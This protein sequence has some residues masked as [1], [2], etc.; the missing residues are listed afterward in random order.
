MSL[1]HTLRIAVQDAGESVRTRRFAVTLL[2]YLAIS[3]LT[4]NGM[5]SVLL[6]IETEVRQLLQLPAAGRGGIITDAVWQSRWFRG[7]IRQILQDDAAALDL[8]TQHPLAV[9]YGRLALFYTPL[10]V[11]LLV[12]ARLSDELGSGAIRYAAARVTRGAWLA[13]KFSGHTATTGLAILM[14]AVGAWIVAR[15]RLPADDGGALA[16]GMGWAALRTWIYAVAFI[17]IGCGLGM[18][19]RSSGRAM[20]LGILSLLVLG[21]GGM[22]AFWLE[23]RGILRGAHLLRSLLPQTYQIDLWRLSFSRVLSA[24]AIMAGFAGAG[25]GSGHAKLCR[26][27]L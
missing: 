13:G 16:I 8:F 3:L 23:R 17:G 6:R 10:L 7:M 14:G 21:A 18:F 4:M 19:T 22:I 5:I 24:C 27:D 20:A 9:A 2:L 25:L 1:A 12:P 26:R 15:L 11:M